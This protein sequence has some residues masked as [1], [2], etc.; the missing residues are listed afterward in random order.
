[1]ALKSYD[2]TNITNSK[3]F[4][5][6]LNTVF[7]S[8]SSRNQ[9]VQDLLIL[10]VAQSAKGGNLGWVSDVYNFA[11]ETKG[12][13]A[14]RIHTYIKEYLYDNTVTFDVKKKVFKKSVKADA[15]TPLVEQANTWFGFGKKEAVK[16]EKNYLESVTTAIKNAQSDTKG[17]HSSG[18]V[19]KAVLASGISLSAMFD[20]MESMVEENMEEKQVA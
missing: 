6:A 4:N 12:V 18:E 20:I 9:Q 8:I 14:T 13:N 2:A 10:G 11:I 17:M 7:G 5:T 1:M 15:I 3:Q 16:K 19:I